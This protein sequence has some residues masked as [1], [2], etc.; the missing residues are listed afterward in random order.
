MRDTRLRYR[1]ARV[2]RVAARFVAIGVAVALLGRWST[3]MSAR[4]AIAEF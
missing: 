2:V 4:G 1:V 3:N